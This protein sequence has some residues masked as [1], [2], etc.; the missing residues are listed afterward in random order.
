MS[1][2]RFM[3]DEELAEFSTFDA[4]LN[5]DNFDSEIDEF[6]DEDYMEKPR[7]RKLDNINIQIVSTM[8]SEA[9]IQLFNFMNSF[10]KVLA[11]NLITPEMSANGVNLIPYDS[12][13]GKQR[14]AK[15]I[16][17][18]FVDDPAA[19]VASPDVF[20][21]GLVYFDQE[22]KLILTAANNNPNGVGSGKITVQLT[23]NNMTYRKFFEHSL[24]KNLKITGFRF[25]YNRADQIDQDLQTEKITATGGQK[26]NSISPRAFFK[27]EQ[28]QNLIV[29]VPVGTT[30]NPDSGLIYK[31][32]GNGGVVATP[33]IINLSIFL[34]S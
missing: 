19:T 11:R 2:R 8:Y 22:G 28:Q 3:L 31:I 10:T 15:A 25:V 4:D 32:L 7:A 30:I 18:A 9:Q 21:P 13:E 16:A 1:K 34:E 12:Y 33:N 27:P 14:V 6:D 5:D 29:D 17:A 20:V 23:G 26:G 24:R